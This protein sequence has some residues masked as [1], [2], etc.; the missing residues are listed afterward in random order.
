[1][2]KR[3]TRANTSRQRSMTIGSRA[4]RQDERRRRG[5]EYPRDCNI[6]PPLRQ[7]RT[8]GHHALLLSSSRRTW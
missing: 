8:E 1:M 3:A 4:V 5:G 2:A 6:P 7:T